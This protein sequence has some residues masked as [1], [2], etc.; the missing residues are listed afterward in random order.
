MHKGEGELLC[1]I[2]EDLD[3]K[4]E[5]LRLPAKLS[6]TPGRGERWIWV[7]RS[8]SR[9]SRMAISLKKG[10]EA[11]SPQHGD[12]HPLCV[13][14][15]SFDDMAALIEEELR[16]DDSEFVEGGIARG[17][18]VREFL[19][20]GYRDHRDQ[21]TDSLQNTP[22][23][24]ITPLPLPAEAERIIALCALEP[25]LDRGLRFLSTGEL[26]RSL[27][28]RCLLSRPDLLILDELFDAL[29]K[30]SRQTMREALAT[31]Q[32]ESLWGPGPQAKRPRATT[33]SIE[34]DLDQTQQNF[35]HALVLDGPQIVHAGEGCPR[36]T[37]GATPKKDRSNF[38]TEIR[39]LATEAHAQEG[40]G[41][42]LF[43]DFDGTATPLIALENVN[44]GWGEHQVLRDVC[45]HIREGEHW[46]LEGPNGSGKT[47]LL[48]LV[49]G[50]NTQAFSNNVYIMG[51]KRGSGETIWDLKREMGQVSWHVH[52]EYRL[53][54]DTRLDEV[55]ASGLHDS[56]GL[57]QPMGE[58]T[59]LLARHWLGFAG[60]AG[61]ED[62]AFA[63]LDWGP[64]RVIIILRA[65][66]KLPRLLILDLPGRVPGRARRE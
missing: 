25:F 59:R 31:W 49:S 56:I 6:L 33:I 15:L 26:R 55:L 63:S 43:A 12:K 20:A 28:A 61:Q 30:R 5:E 41:A 22:P 48:G 23:D 53:L 45:W 46:R 29:D 21:H 14:S 51:R 19:A 4:L 54:G 47:T 7:D 60:F 42:S 18:S 13:V 62:R 36:A 3:Q 52:R 2:P 57:Y 65:L 39:Q 58:S 16:N 9:L 32:N 40:L 44:V 66:I 64:Q 37:N 34:R 24:T 27:L 50:E 1:S 11:G 8:D 10:L 38:A 35:D 17:R